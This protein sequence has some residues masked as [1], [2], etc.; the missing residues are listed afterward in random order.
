M[1][2]SKESRGY[3]ELALMLALI[4][5]PHLSTASVDRI[6]GQHLTEELDHAMSRPFFHLGQS[7]ITL[8][9]LLKTAI[10]LFLLLVISRF[11]KRFVQK[12]ILPHTSLGLGQQYAL[13]RVVVY[14][15]VL[16]G[17][18]VGVQSAGVN[19][20]SLILGYWGNG[21]R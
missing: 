20:N 11:A 17:L 9:F 3:V 12:R 16:V 8:A 7:P 18:M 4:F 1:S 2:R 13:T 19:L 10:Y 14:A 5:A 6:W 21:L 15:I